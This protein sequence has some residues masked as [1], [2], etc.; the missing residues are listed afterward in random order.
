M[1]S[2][3]LHHK[4]MNRIQMILGYIDLAE[5]AEEAKRKELLDRARREIRDLVTLLNEHRREKK[6]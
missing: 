3:M 2:A 4:V 6:K 1:I 5:A